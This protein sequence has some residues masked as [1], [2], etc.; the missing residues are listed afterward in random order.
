MK[1]VGIYVHFPFC[2]SKCKYCNFNSY[3]DK[4]HLQLD[5]FRALLKELN[6]Y[7]LKDICID[8]IFIGGG[9]PSLMFDGAISTLL[10]EIKKSFNVLDNAEITIEAN[11]NSVTLSKAREWKESGV[12]RVSVGL[13]T[14]NSSSLRII[15]RAHTRNDYV[16]AIDI[17]KSVGI[18]NI[19]TD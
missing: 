6:G 18:S 7:L 9:T 1:N 10:S 16:E 12:N 15:G 19:N 2:V 13:Q 11:P 5:Y 4:N 14:T 8:T 3:Q 17:L